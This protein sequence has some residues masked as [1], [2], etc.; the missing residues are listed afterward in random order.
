MLDQPAVQIGR[1][2]RLLGQRLAEHDFRL[3]AGVVLQSV[4]HQVRQQLGHALRIAAHRRQRSFRPQRRPFALD[5]V[6][7]VKPRGFEGRDHVECLRTVNDPSG[8]AQAEQVVDQGAQATAGLDQVTDIFMPVRSELVAIVLGEEGAESLQGTQWFFQ[9]VRDDIAEIV[10]FA[11][12]A[13]QLR[14]GLLQFLRLV[15]QGAGQPAEFAVGADL[16]R[17]VE[18]KAAQVQR[19]ILL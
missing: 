18:E 3:A 16:L 13:P 7:K 15:V 1:G 5:E 6:R 14:V 8:P 19:N 9:V 12:D 4:A 11:I 17:N 10:E 2:V